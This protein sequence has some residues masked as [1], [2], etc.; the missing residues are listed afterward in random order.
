MK[1]LVTIVVVLILAATGF[2]AWCHFSCESIEQQLAAI[3]AVEKQLEGC[4][5]LAEKVKCLREVA[6]DRSLHVFPSTGT[7]PYCLM[8]EP[9]IPNEKI[10]ELTLGILD[11]VANEMPPLESS[12]PPPAPDPAA[13]QANPAT[14]PPAPAPTAEEVARQAAKKDLLAFAG[15]LA[16][17]YA[18]EGEDAAERAAHLRRIVA[19][20]LLAAKEYVAACKVIAKNGTQEDARDFGQRVL[21]GVCADDPAAALPLLRDLF[22]QSL[23]PADVI[24]ASLADL[25]A[26]MDAAKAK[27]LIAFA[28]KE[29]A[30]A[31]AA[32]AADNLRAKL[33]GTLFKAKD[34]AAACELLARVGN[35][36]EARKIVQPELSAHC[37]AEGFD[38]LP[39]LKK[40]KG[41]PVFTEA[42]PLADCAEA[43][44]GR[45]ATPD[46]KAKDLLTFADAELAP[47]C[48]PEKADSLRAKVVEYYF[49]AKDYAAARAVLA[50]TGN[51]STQ[52]NRLIRKVLTADVRAKDAAQVVPFLKEMAECPYFKS[53]DLIAQ[54]VENQIIRFAG[55]GN[56]TQTDVQ[57]LKDLISFAETLL[58]RCSEDGANSL[59]ERRL[60]A[61]FL[62]GDYD[63]AITLLESGKLKTRSPGWCAGTAAKLRAHKAMAAKNNKDAIVHLLA[64]IK[65][66]LSDEQKDF[67]DCDPTT[68]IFY[69]REWV[70]ARNYMRCANM[71]AE[72][73]DDTKAAEYK[74]LAK[75]N[76]TIALKKA[77]DDTKSLPV[78]KE[79]AK[80]VGL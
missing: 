62:V 10:A 76:F 31:C 6:N 67:E 71:A 60:D 58:P 66:M 46:A 70:V 32:E 49:K 2:L 21:S 48:T 43:A 64:F 65:F 24:A 17:A 22:T 78:L 69:S 45:L 57:R 55:N 12:E 4:A 52:A 7:I 36:P 68:G 61:Y 30:P 75:K 74:E 54:L 23:L 80:S 16:D 77:K 41:Y 44:I 34:E 20:Q 56:E 50:K 72:M 26:S 15:E 13:E 79:E 19:E 63:S 38:I 37:S 8:I 25:I 33:A 5:T 1:K 29:L 9:R 35:T 40:I 59:I 11:Q 73:K 53:A 27:D 42:D 51:N 3:Q 47:V 18:A 39:F 14:P 28:D